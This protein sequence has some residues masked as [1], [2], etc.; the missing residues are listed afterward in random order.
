MNPKTILFIILTLY[1]YYLM[2]RTLKNT[3]KDGPLTKSEKVQVILL[4]I[5]N[6]IF[7]WAIFSFGWKKQLPIKSKQVNRYMKNILITLI[8][9]AIAGVILSALLI[10]IN[11]AAQIKKA[12]QIKRIQQ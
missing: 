10:A 9:I 6:T 4:L 3:Q 8:G 11:P 12:N 1:S 2:S 5:F 7:S